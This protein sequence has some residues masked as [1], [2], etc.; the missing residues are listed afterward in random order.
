MPR[1]YKKK[2]QKERVMPEVIQGAIIEVVE[3]E[4]SIRATA[5]THG[6]AKSHLA[7]LVSRYK[8]DNVVYSPHVGNRKVFTTEQE[9]ELALYL[10]Q[11][12]SMNHGLTTLQTR[13]LAFQYAKLV[14]S[15]TIPKTWFT[16]NQAGLDWLQGFMTR[17]KNLSV[18]TPEAT[19]LAR[20][21]SF[22]KTNVRN[23]FKNLEDVM[24]R[25][26]FTPD[27]IYN[28]DETGFTTVHKPPNVIS[29]KG[30]KQV[31]QVTSGE[32]GQLVTVL[33][34]IN[35][36]G[37]AL[38]PAFV[39]PRVNFKDFMLAGAP[40]QSLGLAH[41]SGWMTAENFLK[42][43]QHFSNFAGTSTSNSHTV[44]LILDN[45]DSHIFIE[46]IK[47]AKENGIVLLTLPPHTSQRL[48]PLDVAIYG[49]LKSRYNVAA[50]NW[51]INHPGKPMTIYD[52]PA[53]VSEAFDASLTRNNILSGF[54]KTGIYPFNSEVFTDDDFLQ[55]EVTNRPDPENPP[56]AVT[57]MASA[58]TSDVP[59]TS[60]VPKTL[61]V[62]PQASTSGT[63][64]LSPQL[65]KPFPKASARKTAKSN[66]RGSTRILTDTP[67]KD[68]IQQAFQEKE[69]KKR[70]NESKERRTKS[71][72]QL[73]QHIPEETES[74]DE[75]S[76]SS[77][78]S[79]SDATSSEGSDIEN[80]VK[81]IQPN[82][83]ILV[84][85]AKK[86]SVVYFVGKVLKKLSDEDLKV[87]FMKK[88]LGC[89]KFIFP[90]ED[91]ISDVTM[92]DIVLKLPHPSQAGGT[93]RASKQFIFSIDFTSYRLG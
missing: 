12:S 27:R 22:N 76:Q 63:S 65:V 14:Q 33:C 88:I 92:E 70:K 89:Y 55:A 37:N 51:M 25:Y 53:L 8:K 56:T 52:V 87:K 69:A 11:A 36:M 81:H 75:G 30:E 4:A 80:S 72:K 78:S 67:E 82:D 32:R 91:D 49:P 39:F 90:E 79:K 58:S 42:C 61:P 85:F 10:M 13:E 48:Q 19:S 46:S 73:L 15:N 21:T 54:A 35:A 60:S 68:K 44:L 23:F 47:F 93:A 28:C 45:H 26:E 83:F 57:P 9:A 6:I 66:R 29:R 59:T 31:A 40:A 17:N 5:S 7:R 41:Q 71:K 24:K 3:K 50:N 74:E 18:R 43:L 84:R 1:K 86:T 20:S 2:K 62:C 77:S 16:N 34:F 64:V 38:P